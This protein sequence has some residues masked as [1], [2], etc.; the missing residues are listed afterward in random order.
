MA[1]SFCLIR[2]QHKN[3]PSIIAQYCYHTRNYNAPPKITVENITD[4]TDNTE[5]KA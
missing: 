1:N 4:S 3:P 2:Q 5:A